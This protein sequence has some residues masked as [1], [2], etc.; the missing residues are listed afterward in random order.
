MNYERMK[1]IAIGYRTWNWVLPAGWDIVMFMR[2][3]LKPEHVINAEWGDFRDNDNYLGKPDIRTQSTYAECV[4]HWFN[5][6]TDTIM[7]EMLPSSEFAS[8]H[9]KWSIKLDGEAF[10]EYMKKYLIP[11]YTREMSNIAFRQ[12]EDEAAA[13]YEARITDRVRL[14]EN[15]IQAKWPFDEND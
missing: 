3:H 14:L 15:S 12:L 7:V 4:R 13:A 6:K 9:R 1:A 10:D 8:D 11:H 2:A 5:V